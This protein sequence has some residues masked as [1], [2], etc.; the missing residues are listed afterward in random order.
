MKGGNP[1]CSFCNFVAVSLHSEYNLTQGD[2][3]CFTNDELNDESGNGTLFLSLSI[4][5][6]VKSMA[7][8]IGMNR[9]KWLRFATGRLEMR[10]PLSTTS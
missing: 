5:S 1:C 6:E 3:S 4:G 8:L 9:S 2:S 10:E 7:D